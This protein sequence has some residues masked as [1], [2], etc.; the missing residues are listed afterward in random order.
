MD[1]PTSLPSLNS[2][3]PAET[4]FVEYAAGSTALPWRGWIED[5]DGDTIAWVDLQDRVYLTTELTEDRTG[6]CS[7]RSGAWNA[8]RDAVF[9]AADVPHDPT[10]VDY[11]PRNPVAC[12]LSL[13]MK[14]IGRQL[15]GTHQLECSRYE[16]MLRELELLFLLA[17]HV[18]SRPRG[19]S[20]P[21]W[22]ISYRPADAPEHEIEI[23]AGDKILGHATVEAGDSGLL[24]KGW[25]AGS[26]ST[27]DVMEESLESVASALLALARQTDERAE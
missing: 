13:T 24:W 25:L 17:D 11:W 9:A 26:T 14:Q 21:Y 12:L 8:V 6:T 5:A 23:I 22:K 15:G 19:R 7:A 4:R 2:F 27:P 10:A 1:D 20:D 18:L 3:D 16:H